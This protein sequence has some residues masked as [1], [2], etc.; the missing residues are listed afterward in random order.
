MESSKIIS[1]IID[2]GIDETR[3]CKTPKEMVQL[4]ERYNKELRNQI[5]WLEVG[6][7]ERI[8]TCKAR[9]SGIN[10]VIE[11]AMGELKDML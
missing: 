7:A 9:I 10:T 2:T 1:K 11:M 4:I 8:P 6:N 5:S 3:A